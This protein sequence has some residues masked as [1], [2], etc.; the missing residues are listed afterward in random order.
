MTQEGIALVC[1]DLNKT[2]IKEDSWL[3]LSLA[4]GVTQEEDDLLMR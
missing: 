4:M 1:F 2:L 3:N